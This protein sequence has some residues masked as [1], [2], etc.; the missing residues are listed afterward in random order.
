MSL[1]DAIISRH[2]I[3]RGWSADRKYKALTADGTVYFLRISPMEQYE[4]RK[5]Q[6]SH[7]EQVRDLGV[8]VCE[9]VEFGR[10]GEGCYTLL[11]WIEGRDA[12]PVLPEL[13]GE[14]R[15]TYGLE[16]GRMLRA[17]HTLPAPVSTEPWFDRWCRKADGKLA[18]Y[19][20]CPLKYEKGEL[21]LELVAAERHLIE[22]RPTVWHHGDFHCGNLMFD[23]EMRLTV[24][25][26]DRE[27]VGDP[28]YEF[29]RII[30]DVRVGPEFAR[31][32]LDGYFEGNIPG[33]FWR[34]LRLYQCQNMISSLPWAAGFGDEEIR[35]AV[36]NARRVLGWYDDL[37]EVVPNWY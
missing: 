19:E 23:E 8:R 33:E 27:D 16:A 22:N 29:N 35:I 37:R 24:I 2:P 18:A 3:D 17:I 21:F 12:E 30:W 36:E 9:P 25:D 6:F 7:M 26:F 31:G 10:C 20:S 28:W 14:E 1:F 13:T 34:I 15:R 5:L 32:V 11:G 4:N